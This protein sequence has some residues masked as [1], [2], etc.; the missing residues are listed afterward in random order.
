MRNNGSTKKTNSRRKVMQQSLLLVSLFI[1]YLFYVTYLLHYVG[2]H[3]RTSFTGLIVSS[4]NGQD[5][6]RYLINPS[7]LQLFWFY[8]AIYFSP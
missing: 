8:L 7:L 6:V 2:L 3:M 4:C 1:E 5:K